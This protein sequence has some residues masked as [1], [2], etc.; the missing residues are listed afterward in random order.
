MN[1][2]SC[3]QNLVD[4][5]VLCNLITVLFVQ[6]MAWVTDKR[7]EAIDMISAY[8]RGGMLPFDDEFEP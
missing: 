2:F 3:A 5:E 6:T 1:F 8:M 7:P 4:T